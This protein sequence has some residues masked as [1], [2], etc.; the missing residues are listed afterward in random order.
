MISKITFK[1]L[2]P[3]D[4]LAGPLWAFVCGVEI[5]D[6]VTVTQTNAGG[7][8][9][10][11]TQFFVEG[12]HNTVQPLRGGLFDWTM[13]LDLTPRAWYSRFNGVTYFTP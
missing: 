8:G 2:D 7:G 5:S 10:K 6:V 11:A 1:S 4:P 13:S 12:I 3:S 9:F